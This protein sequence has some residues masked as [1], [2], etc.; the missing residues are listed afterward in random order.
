[1]GKNNAYLKSSSS[2]KS[3]ECLT[4]RYGVLPIVKHLK[5]KGY[6][7]IWCPFDQCNSMFVRVLQAEGFIVHCSHLGNGYDFF[8][9][10][11]RFFVPDCIVSNPPFSCK[12]E[13][14]KRLYEIGLPFAVILPQNAL[15]SLKRVNMFMQ[16]GME[17]LGFDRR[18]CYYTRGE[19]NYWPS[20][21][22]FASAYYCKD[23]LPERMQF[24]KLE[25]IQEPYFYDRTPIYNQDESS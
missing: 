6:K 25:P 12:D 16:H 8:K 1:M 5:A 11:P 22:H 2:P 13:V 9:Y 15:Q 4:P 3:D 18:I 20:A 7:K 17:Y 14:L 21:N 19:L 24:E 10:N 23:V